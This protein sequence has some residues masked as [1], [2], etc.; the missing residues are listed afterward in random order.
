M[1]KR[2]Q[3]LAGFLSRQEL[4]VTLALLDVDRFKLVNDEHGHDV[5]DRVLAGFGAAL[6]RVFRSSDCLARWGGDE[7]LVALPQTTANEAQ[8]VLERLRAEIAEPGADGLPII[9]VSIG[10]VE[11]RPGVALGAT[12]KQADLALYQAKNGGRNEL[13]LLGQPTQPFGSTAAQ[14]LH[15]ARSSPSRI[16]AI[17]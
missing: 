16:P 9:T 12:L 10:A 13:I 17:K 14:S 2:L 7:F 5:G 1:E 3:E 15:Q 6:K 11:W 4:V 8:Q